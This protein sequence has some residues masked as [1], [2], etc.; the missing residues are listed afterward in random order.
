M[1]LRFPD[2]NRAM[3]FG[4][5]EGES[6]EKIFH[7]EL[8]KLYVYS[9]LKKKQENN[10]RQTFKILISRCIIREIRQDVKYPLVMSRANTTSST[11][12]GY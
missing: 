4:N 10:Q 11:S 8:Q 2:F 12:N 1:G 6:E 5:H 9:I 7:L 3:T